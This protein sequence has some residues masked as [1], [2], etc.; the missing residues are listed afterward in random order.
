MTEAWTMK[1]GADSIE[2]MCV[3]LVVTPRERFGLAAQSL[4]GIFEHTTLPC[5]LIYVEGGAPAA[6]RR[7]VRGEA[8]ARGFE[9]VGSDRYLSPNEARNIGWKRAETEFVV[10]IDN[11]VI[12]AAGWLEALV[13]CAK[14]SGADVVAPLICQGL[15][16][17]SKVHQAGG[18]FADDAARFLATERGRRLL[19]EELNLHGEPVALVNPAIVE[20]QLCEF[21][22]MLVRR[23]L[24]D[25]IGPLD[26]EM[27]ATREHLDFCMSVS[28]IGGKMVLEP[29]SVVTYLD[30]WSVP[31]KLRDWPY[32]LVRWSE[33][34]Q[35]RSIDRFLAKWGLDADQ[36]CFRNR[37]GRTRARY[38]SNIIKPFVRRIPLARRSRLVRGAGTRTVGPISRMLGRLLTRATDRRRATERRRN[39]PA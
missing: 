27:L 17:H 9:V 34:W 6:L 7:H 36:E 31:L 19:N 38:N 28:S 16:L 3:T 37:E 2:D 25:R 22:C 13:G 32:F 26:E 23:D 24:I 10:F 35:R 21:H 14:A 5:K 18:R 30:P 12:P 29:R 39:L 20:T 11:D 15:P 4:A 1:Q 8:A 33:S